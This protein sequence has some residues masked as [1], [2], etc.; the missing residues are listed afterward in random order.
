MATQP[1]PTSKIEALKAAGVFNARAEQVHHPLFDASEFFDPHDLPQLKYEA[2]RAMKQD[3]YPLARAAKEFGLSR[4]TL[5]Q[6]QAQL[7]QQGL[8]GLLP[9]KRGPKNPHKLT[10]AVRQYLQE[11]AAANPELKPQDLTRQLRQRFRVKLHP[12]TVE[13]ALKAKAKRGPQIT[14]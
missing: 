2:L 9:R 14:P 5:Y 8:E 10:P 7:E 12:R 4:P 1:D 13:K 3:Q 6:A 11:T